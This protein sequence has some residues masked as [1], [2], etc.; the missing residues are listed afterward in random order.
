MHEY[1]GIM[2]K[3][4]LKDPSIAEGLNI[5]G[6]KQGKKLTLLRISVEEDR[7]NETVKLIQMNLISQPSY[8]SHFYRGEE[9]IVVFPEKIFHATTNRET[10]QKII[11]Y[12]RSLGIPKKE[13]DFKP[14]RIEDET[15]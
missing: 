13:L 15:Y 11:E 3:D 7:I 9:L 6:K 1:H 14:C 12:G 8:Y 4:G 5:L 10:W 2:I